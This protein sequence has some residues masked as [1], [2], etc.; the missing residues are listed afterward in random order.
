[1][2]KK[3]RVNPVRSNIVIQFLQW[4][5]KELCNGIMC[6]LASFPNIFILNSFT[7]LEEKKFKKSYGDQRNLVLEIV[8]IISNF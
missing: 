6:S 1:M 7:L 8:H 2:R 4:V 3:R 5:S